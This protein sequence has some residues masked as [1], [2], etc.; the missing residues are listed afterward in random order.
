M[1]FHE[2]IVGLVRANETAICPYMKVEKLNP[3]GLRKGAATH[4]LAGT[5]APP[6]IA[7]VARRGEWTISTVL[8]CYWHYGAV[9]DHYLGRILCGLDP[10]DPDFAVLPPHWDVANPMG[11]PTI[12]EAMQ[13]MY[14][15]ILDEYSSKPADPTGVLLRCLACVV[16]NA[17]HLTETMVKYPGHEF[18]KLPILHNT[19]LLE[20]LQ[21]L[22]TTERTPG[23]FLFFIFFFVFLVI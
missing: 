3:Y 20:A 7:S 8:D 15:G 6:S 12:R 16:Y 4:A 22:V 17:K 10:N 21:T 19:V 14:G 13:L 23:E 2:Q 18:S 5:T 1:K 11:N 9:G